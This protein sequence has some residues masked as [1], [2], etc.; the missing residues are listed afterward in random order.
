LKDKEPAPTS[1]R[2]QTLDD[3]DLNEHRDDDLNEDR[4]DDRSALYGPNPK[5]EGRVKNFD[6]EVMDEDTVNK[7]D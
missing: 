6:G 7:Y 1:R 2:I 3:D 5:I 4:D